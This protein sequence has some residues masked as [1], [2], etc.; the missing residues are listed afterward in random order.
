MID[1]WP[2]RALGDVAFIQMGQSPP[3]STYNTS[4]R[5]L[6]FLQ[7]SAEFGEHYPKPVKWCSA[8]AKVAEPGDLMLSVRAPV[9][10]TNFADQRL[11]IGRG[12]AVIRGRDGVLTEYLRMVVQAGTSDLLERSGS[13]MF[14]SITGANLRAFQVPMAPEAEQRRIVD[15]IGALDVQIEA[16]NEECK[17]V[18]VLLGCLRE[19]LVAEAEWTPVSNMTDRGGIQIGPF[20]SQLHARDYTST[21]VPVVMPQDLARGQ[22]VTQKIKYVSETTAA[23]L[24]R[25]RMRPGDLVLPRRGDLRKRA[26]VTSEQDG[27]LC[28][29]GCIRIRLSDPTS[30]A[31]LIE[32]L[33][34]ARTDEWLEVHAVGTTMLNLNTDIVS[35]LPAPEFSEAGRAVAAACL[36]AQL[37]V[38]ELRVESQQLTV[39]RQNILQS[40]MTGAI[41]LPETYDSLLAEAV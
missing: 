41:S 14:A 19:S 1:A 3:G 31:S 18:Q 4:Q 15:L 30:A 6:P 7:G 37:T 27:W 36:A 12:L 28:G 33:S 9:G 2:R 8:P 29:T 25:H 40:V 5:G 32:G 22:I 16:L 11:A 17:S 13:G 26:L 23:M 38:R 34:T 10:D 24:A 39:A 20:G 21:G 35:K